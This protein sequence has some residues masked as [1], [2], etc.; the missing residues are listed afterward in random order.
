MPACEFVG[1]FWTRFEKWT[2]FQEQFVKDSGWYL[3]PQFELGWHRTAGADYELTGLPVDVESMTSLRARAGL[4]FGKKRVYDNGRSLEFFVRASVV[5]EFDGDTNVRFFTDQT[6]TAFDPF[7]VD[8]SGT[9]GQYKLGLNYYAPDKGFT[10]HGA[11]TYENGG[12][13]E[14]PIGLELGGSW[15]IGPKA[16]EETEK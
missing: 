14:S 1:L 7:K 13:R 12:D 9:W 4:G 5:K 8:Y 3:E 6:K 11:L 15:N 2:G 10:L 16:E